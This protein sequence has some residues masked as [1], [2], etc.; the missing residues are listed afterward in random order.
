MSKN[1]NELK[2][3]YNDYSQYDYLTR[4]EVKELRKNVK[5]RK[6]N[7]DNVLCDKATYRYTRE[8]VV[9]TSYYTDVC[10]I[11]LYGDF[12]KIWHGYSKTTLKHI[13]MF[14]KLWSLQPM[15]KKEWVLFEEL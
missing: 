4:D 9:L 5:E 11:D 15:N 7:C 3:Y 13:N 12:H 6:N 8:G 14:R 10:Y 1:Y 2:D